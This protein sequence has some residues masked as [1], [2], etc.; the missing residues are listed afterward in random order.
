MN[1]PLDAGIDSTITTVVSTVV[2]LVIEDAVI[3]VG[4]RMA[5]GTAVGT[6]LGSWA[7]GAGNAIGAAAGLLAGFGADV[8]MSSRDK[9]KTVASVDTTLL[10]IEQAVID[11]DDKHA[12]MS[13]IMDTAV[14]TQS[15]AMSDATLQ[16]LAESAR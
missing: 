1:V 11:G 7:P 9:A 16:A 12:G 2:T 10:H 15:K 4:T 13:R 14:D 8:W 5:A 3:S 6:A